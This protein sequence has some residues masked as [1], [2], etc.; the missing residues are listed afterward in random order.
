MAVTCTKLAQF[1]IYDR[2]LKRCE[3]LVIKYEWI[4]YPLKH[5]ENC[6]YILEESV[7]NPHTKKDPVHPLVSQKYKNEGMN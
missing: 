3:L 2:Y 6:K 5:K 1:H 7:K 4:I